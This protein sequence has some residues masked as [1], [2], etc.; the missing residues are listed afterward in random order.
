MTDARTQAVFFPYIFGDETLRVDLLGCELDGKTFSAGWNP[1]AMECDLSSAGSWESGLLRFK[2][3]RDP[4]SMWIPDLVP[5]SERQKPSV[6]L[7]AS[8]HCAATFRREK[9]EGTLDI[10]GETGHIDVPLS[11]ENVVGAVDLNVFVVRATAQS[12]EPHLAEDAAARI[13][14][15]RRVTVRID[16]PERR[17]GPGLNIEWESFKASKHPYRAGHPGVLFHLD[18]SGTEP[19]LFLNKDADP[20]LHAILTDEAPR[21][22]KAVLRNVLFAAIA[23]PVWT[24]LLRT[25]LT[26]VDADGH[27]DA[28][29]QKNVLT[30]LAAIAEPGCD[31][32]EGSKRFIRDLRDPAG[33]RGIEERLPVIIAELTGFRK[34]AEDLAGVIS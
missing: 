20:D 7:I 17:P 25:A 30:E 34:K 16:A 18:T 14:A 15:A 28:G 8:A 13:I 23:F 2:V 5:Q 27:I 9:C 26:A 10:K 1:D 19:V 31:R 24:C 4:S 11:R 21:G 33:G 6:R 29:W 12:V 22:K 3:S 32:E